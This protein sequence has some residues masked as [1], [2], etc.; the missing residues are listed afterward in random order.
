ME[1]DIMQVSGEKPPRRASGVWRWERG[2]V[3][4]AEPEVD[5][6]WLGGGGG[7]KGALRGTEAAPS[8]R[9]AQRVPTKRS[10]TC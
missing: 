6:G 8:V 9:M 5:V 1:G 2:G 4:K 3:S 10:S 7:G